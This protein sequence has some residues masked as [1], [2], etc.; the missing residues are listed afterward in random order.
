MPASRYNFSIEQG[1]SFRMSLI[2]KDDLGNPINLTGYCA[3]L[4]W[5]TSKGAVQNFSTLNV[6]YSVYKFSIE[7]VIGKLT[8][9]IPASVTNNFMFETAKYDLE[10]QSGNDLYN[11]GGKY[12][13]RIIYGVITIIQRYSG[14]EVPL[15]CS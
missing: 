15:E 2:Y 6:D 8:L 4:T 3:R 1:S 10:L 12:T 7:P 11:G 9:L 14:I 13:T 5:T